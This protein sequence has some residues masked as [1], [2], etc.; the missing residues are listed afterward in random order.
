[1]AILKVRAYADF[2]VAYDINLATMESKEKLTEVCNILNKFCES[3]PECNQ[4]VR[5]K[6]YLCHVN[7]VENLKYI[8]VHGTKMDRKQVDGFVEKLKNICEQNYVY[9]YPNIFSVE[10]VME[11]V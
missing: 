9:I 5:L 7:W 10:E 8:L 1:M 11:L 6:K 2:D 4:D 3:F